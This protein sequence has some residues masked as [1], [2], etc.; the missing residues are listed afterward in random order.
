M[1]NEGQY[2]RYDIKILRH[3]L[4]ICL[5][6]NLCVNDY[7]IFSDWSL[8]TILSVPRKRTQNVVFGGAGGGGHESGRV[9]AAA[10]PG[11]RGSLGDRGSCLLP[12][13]MQTREGG[14]EAWISVRWQYRTT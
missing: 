3:R 8:H 1:A 2:I 6:I 9:L 11:A 5:Y 13:G 4:F 7:R 14:W 10:A 12:G